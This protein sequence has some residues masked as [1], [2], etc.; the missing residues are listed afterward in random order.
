MLKASSSPF[1]STRVAD[2]EGIFLFFFHSEFQNVEE[3]EYFRIPELIPRSPYF[4]ILF[5][6]FYESEK[7]KN[8]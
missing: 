6:A 8:P 2:S 1:T 5:S 3:Q 7:N 4:L